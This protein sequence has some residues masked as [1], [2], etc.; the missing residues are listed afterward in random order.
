MEKKLEEFARECMQMES[1]MKTWRE[2]YIRALWEMKQKGERGMLT[3]WF[4]FGS[5]RASTTMLKEEVM[6]EV[7]KAGSGRAEGKDQVR[8]DDMKKG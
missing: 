2:E 3:G 8:Y 1:A 6:D 5:P 4:K 7:M